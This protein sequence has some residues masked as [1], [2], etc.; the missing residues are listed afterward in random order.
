[1]GAPL[2]ESE[3]G[4]IIKSPEKSIGTRQMQSTVNVK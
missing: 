2:Y 1:M 3:V 4:K